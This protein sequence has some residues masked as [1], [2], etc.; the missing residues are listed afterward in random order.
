MVEGFSLCILSSFFLTVIRVT[1]YS[2]VQTA[3]W[4]LCIFLESWLWAYSHGLGIE[5][6]QKLVI[7]W[8]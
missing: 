8:P 5:V 2:R 7:E 4:L 3:I 6:S 1:L